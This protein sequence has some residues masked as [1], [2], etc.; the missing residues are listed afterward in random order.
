[1]FMQRGRRWARTAAAL[2][3]GGALALGLAGPA[4]AA[5]ATGTAVSVKGTGVQLVL[6]GKPMTTSEL[7]LKIDGKQVPAYCIDFHT[8]VALNGTYDE[9][10]W[11]RSG[12]AAEKLGKVQW[13]LTH[14]YPNGEAT[15]LLTAA[16]AT[17]P[18]GVDAAR[19]DVLLYFGTQTAIWTFSDDVVLG[20]WQDGVK[21]GEQQ[22]AVVKKVHDYLVAHAT[23]QPEPKA[24]L[25]VD[26]AKATATAGGK[27]GPFTVTGPAGEITVAATGGQAVDEAGKPVTTIT[28]GGRFWL[29]RD[30]AGEVSVTLKA[31][32]SVS[33]GRVFLYTGGKAQKLILGGSTGETVRAEAV[34][35][36]TAVPASPS[37]SP[38]PSPSSASASP[39]APA[40]SPSPSTPAGSPAPST[41]P[42]SNGGGLPLTGSPVA[43]AATVGVLLLAAGAVAVLIVRRRKVR[44]TA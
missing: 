12:I 23:D 9:G 1:M 42:A 36:F 28:N 26:P 39:S 10:S 38:S 22:Y 29:T 18:A 32:N 30:G 15:A 24:D 27:A 43:A 19:R 7:A 11:D 33:F 4:R 5:D 21:L 34:A 2:V 17:V 31:E 35:S 14:G 16:G 20:D 13:V 44:F 3:A 40:E 41:S 37:A 25:T 8:Q 6:N